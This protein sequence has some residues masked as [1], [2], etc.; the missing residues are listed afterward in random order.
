M[1]SESRHTT[2]T[3]A[4]VRPTT[5]APCYWCGFKRADH[6]GNAQWADTKLRCPDRSAARSSF[7]GRM[8]LEPTYTA[9]N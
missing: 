2:A 4:I 9:S 3:L 8:V 5:A 7:G 6:Y 1:S